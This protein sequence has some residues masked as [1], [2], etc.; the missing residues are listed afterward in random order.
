MPGFSGQGKVWIG[1]VVGGV[2][3]PLV[4]MG[5]ALS[6]S[7]ALT[8]DVLERNESFSGSRLPLCRTTRAKQ[9]TV[10]LSGDEWNVDNLTRLLQATKTTVAA[11]AAVVGEL[12]PPGVTV[13]SLV[14]LGG[15]NVTAVAVQDSTGAPKTLV[16]NTNYRLHAKTGAIEFIDLTVGGPYVQ[17]VKTN[18]TPGARDV[19]ALFNSGNPEQWIRFE[20]INTDDNTE[21]LVDLYRVRLSPTRE[22]P[23]ILDEYATFEQEGSVLVDTTKPAGGTLG[24]FGRLVLLG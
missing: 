23:L 8:E 3:Q 21:V 10:N 22:L 13:G 19:V 5:N 9:A 16:A 18:Y 24:Q 2:P 12:A 1:N 4:W 11:G 15:Q 7:V 20:G 6:L 17:Q 14:V